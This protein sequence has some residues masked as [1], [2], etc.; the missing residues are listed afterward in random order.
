MRVRARRAVAAAAVLL[1]LAPAAPATASPAPTVAPSPLASNGFESPS[2]TTPAL[3]AQLSI[4]EQTNCG[5]SG[6][7]VAP[8]PLSNY[9]IDVNIPAGI[10]ASWSDD[11]DGVVQDLLVTPVWTALV[12]LVHVVLIALE[13]C[14]S[15]DLLAPAT[16]TR[17]GAS[18]GAAKRIFTAPRI[19][20]TDPAPDETVQFASRTTLTT[21]RYWS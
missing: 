9:A 18:L 6:V 5:V 15:L 3:E 2:C 20:G 12:W 1:V 16:L 7:A 10:G 17:A 21:R 19:N 11:L 4:A 13:W 8:V 14:Y